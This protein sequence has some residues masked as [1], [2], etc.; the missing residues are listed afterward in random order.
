[1]QETRLYG[2]GLPSMSLQVKAMS[3]INSHLSWDL[4]VMISLQQ[5]VLQKAM[6]HA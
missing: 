2:V 5:V 3:F 4:V 6:L 1:M